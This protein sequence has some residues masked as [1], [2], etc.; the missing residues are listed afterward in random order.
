MTVEQAP[1]KLNLVLHVGR[2][3]RDGLHELCS[4]FASLELADEVTGHP[5]PGAEG[6]RVECA[7]VDGPNLALSALEAY[8]AEAPAGADLPPL[9][10]TIAK[11]VPVA[12]GLGGGSADAAAALRLADALSDRPLGA[13]ALRRLAAELG[14][15]V[16][17]QV[18][19]RHAIVTGAGEG[20]RPV[21]LGPLEIV[22]VP[23][24]RGL[25]TADVYAEL[26]RLGGARGDLD[27]GPL[28]ELAGAGPARVA[29]AMENDLQQ[30]TLSLRPD[31]ASTLDR[32]RA[33]GALAAMVAGSGP[34]VFGVFET[35]AAADA[36]AAAT[37]GALRT[38]VAEQHA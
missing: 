31:L 17:S 5:A 7:G 33:Q 35:A 22:L 23:S 16:P 6:D 25:A 37:D 14:S 10:V 28:S 12:A 11:R 26:D 8:R 9:A 32:L 24:T 20:V 34:T 1:A 15:D 3:R 2:R 18:E 13:D 30:A 27:C 38:R 19:P 4:L 21:A 36:A 29:A